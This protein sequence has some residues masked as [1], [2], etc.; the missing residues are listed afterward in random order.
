MCSSDLLAQEPRTLVEFT[1]QEPG[2]PALEHCAI[3]LKGSYGSFRQIN[4]ARP[5]FSVR[6]AKSTTQD[7]HGL[8][9]FQLNNCAQDGTMLHEPLAG[10]I[11]RAAGVPALIAELHLNE[12]E[13]LARID[14]RADDPLRTS[15]ATR[16]VYLAQATRFE[17]IQPG[18]G[19]HLALDATMHP[20][21][22]A[23]EIAAALA[24]A[25]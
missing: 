23:R 16:E 4:D 19:L 1:L 12:A 22:I 3:K 5:G 20:A 9:K 24:K 10:E 18:E 8:T 21:A 25:D 11:A 17:A 13:A 15:D 7:F 6:T 2:R 14:G